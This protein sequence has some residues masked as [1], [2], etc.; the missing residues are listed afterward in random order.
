M[1]VYYTLSGGE[2]QGVSGMTKAVE[3]LFRLSS[4]ADFWLA[5]A[6]LVNLVRPVG[7]SKLTKK[8]LLVDSSDLRKRGK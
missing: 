1:Y 5:I 3:M 8:P 6:F 2:T 4:R 7:R